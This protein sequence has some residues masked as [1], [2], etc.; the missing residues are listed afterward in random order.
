VNAAP[1][2]D[3]DPGA[4]RLGRRFS[5]RKR[6]LPDRHDTAARSG[7]R[8]SFGRAAS[9]RGLRASHFVIA[10]GVAVP[11]MEAPPAALR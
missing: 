2:L 6:P 5:R 4:S 1:C 10:L 7:A 8:A 9:L 11:C 3:R